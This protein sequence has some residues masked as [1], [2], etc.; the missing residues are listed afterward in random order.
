MPTPHAE[1]LTA[2]APLTVIVVTWQGADLLRDCLGSLRGQ[3]LPHQVLVVDNASTDDTEAVL[4]DFPEAQV[5]RLP[6]NVGFAGGVAQALAHLDSH[7]P[8]TELVALLNNDAVADPDWL[9]NSVDALTPSCAAIT[10]R[11]LLW[12]GVTIN[13]TGIAML[14]NGYGTD[15]GLGERDQ[16]RFDAPAEV[17]G[18]SGGAALLRV[19]ALR[20]VGGF[21][22]EYFLYYEDTDVSWRLQLAG[23]TV[24]YEPSAIVRHRHAASS[25]PSSALFAYYTERNRLF[26]LLRCA[27][28]ALAIGQLGRFALTTLSL[29]VKRVGGR[30]VPN[31]QIFNP[32]LRVRVLAAVLTALPQLTRQ[33]HQI[34]TDAL[35]SRRWVVRRWLS[36]VHEYRAA[37]S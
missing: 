31:H 19:Q 8:E 4:S 21:P 33:R 30:E 1:P 18:F 20:E 25:D 7:A 16:R 23:W 26:T 22:A 12:D 29:T 9:K 17:F 24:K 13:N 37:A 28:A 27:P 6:A 2:G 5:L 14:A 35:R 3:S 10:A 34:S 32:R 15:R 36:S 11:M